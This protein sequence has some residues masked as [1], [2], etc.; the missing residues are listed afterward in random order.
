LLKSRPK[1]SVFYSLAA[2]LGKRRE[3]PVLRNDCMQ[4][5][6]D[7]GHFQCSAHELARTVKFNCDVARRTSTPGTFESEGRSPLG[8]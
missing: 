1:R 5:R 8:C 2:G 7:R 6:G 4:P 3:T